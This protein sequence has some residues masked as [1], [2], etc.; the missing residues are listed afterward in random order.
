M[1]AQRKEKNVLEMKYFVLK[2]RGDDVFARASRAAMRVYADIVSDTDSHLAENLRNWVVT[3]QCN[4]AGL[5]NETYSIA[6]VIRPKT[7]GGH[8]GWEED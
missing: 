5:G 4:A 3:E 6:E 7:P 2:P 8:K 1:S